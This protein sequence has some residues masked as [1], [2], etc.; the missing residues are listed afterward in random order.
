[1]DFSWSEECDKAFEELK[2]YLAHPLILSRIEKEEV[3]CAYIVVTSH[4]VCLALIQVE[5]GIHKLVYYVSKSLQEAEI[6][7][8]LCHKKVST[9]LPSAHNSHP[10]LVAIIG[11]ALEI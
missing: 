5:E 2:T 3:L 8:H 10:H 6:S 11:T 4:L 1:M 7:H 9:L